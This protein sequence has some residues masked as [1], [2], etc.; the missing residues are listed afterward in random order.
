M[1]QIT[2]FASDLLNDLNSFVRRWTINLNTQNEVFKNYPQCFHIEDRKFINCHRRKCVYGRMGYDKKNNVNGETF[3]D[4]TLY[5]YSLM[6][7]IDAM[8]R[9]KLRLNLILFNL[10]FQLP[11]PDSTVLLYYEQFKLA[12]HI[13]HSIFLKMYALLFVMEDPIDCK[14]FGFGMKLGQYVNR[15]LIAKPN[16]AGDLTL[17]F[18]VLAT[19]WNHGV[20]KVEGVATMLIWRW[21]ALW[22]LLND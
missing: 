16:N 5:E 15:N 9:V 22:K 2:G 4:N 13:D 7:E 1:I 8:E 17:L 10:R 20:Q 3:Y 21:A 19:T 11:S 14:H 18:G 6:K 12:E